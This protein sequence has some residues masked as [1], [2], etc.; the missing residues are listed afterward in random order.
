MIGI[1]TS[2]ENP[3]MRRILAPILLIAIAL[4]CQAQGEKDKPNTLTA[5][6]IADGWILLFDGETTFGWKF[7]TQVEAK[8]SGGMLELAGAVETR[9]KFESFELRFEYKDSPGGLYLYLIGK[10][11]DR[12]HFHLPRQNDWATVFMR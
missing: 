1:A 11:A 6:E 2:S 4:P 12:V 5:K 7:P 3:T 9:A 10:E 8:V